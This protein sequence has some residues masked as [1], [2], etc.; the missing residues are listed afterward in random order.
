V[1]G[2]EVLSQRQC[3]PQQLLCLDTAVFQR[4]DVL[5]AVADVWRGVL[6]DGA[7][8]RGEDH[9]LPVW[10]GV[11]HYLLVSLLQL[12][13]VDWGH[14]GLRFRGDVITALL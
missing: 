12:G 10:P 9:V 4:H 3:V 1:D 7:G 14:Q 11:W 13:W 6:C 5:C 8:L 2:R